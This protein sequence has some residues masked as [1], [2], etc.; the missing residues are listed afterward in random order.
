[1]PEVGAAQADEPTFKA[2]NDRPVPQPMGIW[3]LG[4]GDHLA[5]NLE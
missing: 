5:R 2:S 3:E 4:V 1:M